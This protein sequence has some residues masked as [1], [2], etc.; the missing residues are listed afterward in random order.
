MF[1]CIV[2]WVLTWYREERSGRLGKKGKLA[3][4]KVCLSD[5]VLRGWVVGEFVWVEDAV[6]W[7]CRGFT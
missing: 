3:Y 6:V 5:Y 1:G 4:W 7:L 2:G